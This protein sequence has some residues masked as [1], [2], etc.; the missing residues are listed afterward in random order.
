MNTMPARFLASLFLFFP[1]LYGE[2][3][4]TRIVGI[5][6][7]L[8]GRVGGIQGQVELIALVSREGTVRTVR[9]LSGAG[10][11]IPSA[12]EALLRWTFE[13]CESTEGCEVK[14]VFSFTLASGSCDVSEFCPSEF[15]AELPGRVTI[16][17]KRI[18][19][20]VN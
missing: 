14:V 11:L 15:E 12:R 10:P 3:R 13:G 19:A 2:I 9:A 6:Y 4:V 5:E 8:V 20:I 7:P 18:R 16:K 1:A 17:A